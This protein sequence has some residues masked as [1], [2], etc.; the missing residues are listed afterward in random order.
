MIALISVG[1]SCNNHCHFCHSREKSRTDDTELGVH[2]KVEKAVRLG[3]DAVAFSGGEPTIRPE[4]LKWVRHASLRGLRVGVVSN[5]RMLSYPSFLDHL[6]H[7]GLSFVQ[8][9]LQGSEAAVHNTITEV[10][11]FDET[12]GALEA[13]TDRGIEVSVQAVVSGRNC[14]DLVPLVDL[15]VLKLVV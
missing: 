15:V 3:Y 1:T 10:D 4:I 12:L 11:S 13:L 7:A 6:V 8:L 14:E 9:S 2:K 5:G